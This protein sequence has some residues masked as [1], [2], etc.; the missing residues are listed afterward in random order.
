MI[1][2]SLSFE[3]FFRINSGAPKTIDSSLLLLI[4]VIPDSFRELE[5]AI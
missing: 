4:K 3:R 5:K 2:D 1:S